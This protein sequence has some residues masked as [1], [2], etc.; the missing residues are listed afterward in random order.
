M[1]SIFTRTKPAQPPLTERLLDAED[2]LVTLTSDKNEEA[3]R[4]AE[5]AAK[6]KRDAEVAHEK[7]EAVTKAFE[8]LSAANVDI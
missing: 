6:A 4:L 5:L 3:V 8:I 7:R 2:R 1:A